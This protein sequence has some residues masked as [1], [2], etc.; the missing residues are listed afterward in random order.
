MPCSSLHLCS[1]VCPCVARVRKHLPHK[2]PCSSRSSC[3]SSCRGGAPNAIGVIQPRPLSLLPIRPSCGTSLLCYPSPS[4]QLREEPK[5]RTPKIGA[6]P[7]PNPSR[8]SRARGRRA[9]GRSLPPGPVF[10]PSVVPGLVQLDGEPSRAVWWRRR[11]S[12]AT[13]HARPGER[14]RARARPRAPQPSPRP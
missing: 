12:S 13:R 10:A 14:A 4:L 8:A 6:C 9:R 5:N 1:S 7:N 11:W 2:L 3:M